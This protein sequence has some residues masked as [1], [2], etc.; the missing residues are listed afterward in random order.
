M[1]RVAVQVPVALFTALVVAAVQCVF[2]SRVIPIWIPLA[3]VGLAVLAYFRPQRALLA[4][5]VLAPL[6]GLWEPLLGVRMR[7]AEAVVLAFLTGALVRGW[8]IHRFKSVLTDRL[9]ISALVLAAIVSASCIIQLWEPARDRRDFVDYILEHYLTSFRRY[10]SLFFAMLLLEGLALLVY[11]AHY[12]RARP[13]LAAKL[14]RMV[15]I[16]AV[17]AAAYNFWFFAHELMETG[18]PAARLAEF[19][20]QQRW[21][22]H[23]GDVNAAG[24]FFAMTMSMAIGSSLSDRRHR[25]AWAAAGF[26]LGVALW[27]TASRSAITAVL[28][29]GTISLARAVF[30]QSVARRRAVVLTAAAVV[31]LA[32]FS[33]QY[34]L[35][36]PSTATASRA[37]SIR[38]LFLETT[39]HM[40]RTH[41]VAGVG[42]GQ[43][44]RSSGEYAPPELL[45]I[46]R[47][48]NAHNNFAQI[49]GELGLPGL[50][51]FLGVLVVSFSHLRRLQRPSPVTISAIAGLAV[52]ILSWLGGHPLLVPAVAYPFWLTLGVVAGAR[53][54]IISTDFHG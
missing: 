34:F 24:S 53:S 10:G 51:A 40:V 27:M 28:V 5:A 17:A 14:A 50:A 29:V 48:E 15:V 4:V 46:Y 19:F 49:A 12:C 18:E 26:I 7:G 54:D 6:E 38:W 1:R 3:V 8:T 47:S 35:S 36:R 45:A 21:S 13:E 37:V 30:A 43:Y 33:A 32:A 11:A 41:P 25:T 42:I 52:F 44:A 31:A 20:L 16:S 39:L 9:N 22:A 23:V 2:W